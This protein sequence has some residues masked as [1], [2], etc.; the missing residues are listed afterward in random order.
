MKKQWWK[1]G[2]VIVAGVLLSGCGKVGSPA[3]IE[4]RTSGGKGEREPIRDLDSCAQRPIQI[5]G[6]GDPGKQLA[7]CFVEYPGEPSR[8]DKSYYVVEDICGQFTRQFV[9][10]ALGRPIVKTQP[11]EHESLFNCKYVLDDQDNYVLL[12]FEYL[13]IDNQKKGQE[14]MGRTTE[15]SGAIP[16]RNL[17]VKQENGTI[18]TIYLVLGDMKFVSIDRSSGSGL[19]NEEL[20]TFAGNV[21]REI[22]EYK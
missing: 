6:Y 22:K 16:M 12:V 17:V 19:T 3:S 9:Q 7:N 1:L 8:Q 2:L 4:Q 13:G 15:E 5:E 18:N 14:M 21:A 20:L 11:P 10:N